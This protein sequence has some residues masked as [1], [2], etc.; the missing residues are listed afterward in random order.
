[1][2]LKSWPLKSEHDLVH[3]PRQADWLKID[4]QRPS[5]YPRKVEQMLE[6]VFQP[7]RLLFDRAQIKHLLVGFKA[8]VLVDK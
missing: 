2:E 7:V 5:I 8:S 3:D 4:L 1:M 6:E